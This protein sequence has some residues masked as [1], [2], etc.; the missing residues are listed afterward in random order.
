MVRYWRSGHLVHPASDGLKHSPRAG[1]PLERR[2]T[3]PSLCDLTPRDEAPLVLGKVLDARKCTRPGHHCIIPR[4]RYRLQ[5]RHDAIT[6]LLPLYG[7]KCSIGSS[8]RAGRGSGE[9]RYHA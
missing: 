8:N 9:I 6:A 2:H 1:E 7:G 4:I 5:R 3:Y